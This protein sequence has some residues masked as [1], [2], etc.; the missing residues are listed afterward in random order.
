MR[1]R[2]VP[3]EVEL[4]PS[5]SHVTVARPLYNESFYDLVLGQGEQAP[6]RETRAYALPQ[7]AA[8]VSPRLR[9]SVIS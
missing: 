5:P 9:R 4:G 6:Q 7:T 8:L 1:P 2:R 3:L